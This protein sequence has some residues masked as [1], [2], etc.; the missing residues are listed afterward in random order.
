MDNWLQL[1]TRT[2]LEAKLHC[3]DRGHYCFASMGLFANPPCR[4]LHG[5]MVAEGGQSDRENN[6]G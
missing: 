6:Q 3:R 5:E 2:E 1:F 4:L